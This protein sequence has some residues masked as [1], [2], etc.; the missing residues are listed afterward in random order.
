MISLAA[1]SFI[2]SICRLLSELRGL[3]EPEPL[4]L[5][6]DPA[7]SRASKTAGG[8]ATGSIT[9]FAINGDGPRY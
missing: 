9:E 1:L 6:G 7:G 3:G 5:N 2:M 8:T 4:H